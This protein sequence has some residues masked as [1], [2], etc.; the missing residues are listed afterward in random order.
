MRLSQWRAKA[1]QEDSVAPKVMDVV[2]GALA[3]RSAPNAI[4]NVARGDGAS[5]T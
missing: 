1:R 2:G 5:A 3:A 4:P